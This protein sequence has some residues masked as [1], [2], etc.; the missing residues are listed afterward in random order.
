MIIDILEKHTLLNN[1]VDRRRFY[2]ATMND[3]KRVPEFAYRILQLSGTLMSMG[4]T[5][6]DSE[7]LSINLT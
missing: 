6:E 3:K 5:I 2:T 1:L 7:M 4:S